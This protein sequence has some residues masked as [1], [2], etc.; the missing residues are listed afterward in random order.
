[1][2]QLQTNRRHKVILLPILLGLLGCDLAGVAAMNHAATQTAL[3]LSVIQYSTSAGGRFPSPTA[4]AAGV[5]PRTPT[6]SD[7][8]LPLETPAFTATFTPMPSATAAHTT[9]P[10]GTSGITRYITDPVTRDYAPQKKS[11]S[12]SDAYPFNRYER[13]YT[14]ETM[15]YLPDVDLTRVEMKI[16]PPWVFIT[17]FIAGSDGRCTAPNSTS[18]GTGAGNT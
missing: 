13:P 10:P 4:T 15:D 11:P 16:T 17:F 6:A 2:P 5:L 1:M 3:A 18:I 12:G 8:P 14:A 9:T 7:T